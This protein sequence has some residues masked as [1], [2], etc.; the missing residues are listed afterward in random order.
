MF[1]PNATDLVLS[2]NTRCCFR[3]KVF[4]LY[5]HEPWKRFSPVTMLSMTVIPSSSLLQM[6][7]YI[8][9]TSFETEIIGIE[10]MITTKITVVSCMYATC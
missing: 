9:V 7:L 5:Q 3:I 1:T 10:Q 8:P 6:V 4:H 2:G